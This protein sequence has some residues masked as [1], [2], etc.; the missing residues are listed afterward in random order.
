MLAILWNY[1]VAVWRLVCNHHMS[2]TAWLTLSHYLRRQALPR[3]LNSRKFTNS[4][5]Q[6]VCSTQQIGPNR[7]L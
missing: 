7:L 4:S 1:L 2:S 6:P 5:I 3:S